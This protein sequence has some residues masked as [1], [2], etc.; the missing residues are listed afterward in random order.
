MSG[1]DFGRRSGRLNVQGYVDVRDLAALVSFLEMKGVR[2]PP[3]YS[4][5]QEAI[6][7]L[8][9]DS[10]KERGEAKVFDMEEAIAALDI[11]GFS[12]A[13]LGDKRGNGMQKG[14]VVDAGAYDFAPVS[15]EQ[16]ELQDLVKRALATHTGGKVGRLSQGLD[17]SLDRALPS[18]VEEVE[19]AGRT[20][21]M[22]K[23]PANL[24]IVEDLDNDGGEE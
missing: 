13:Q 15:S 19:E 2:I 4:D 5:L 21:R 14:R 18:V 3:R 16:R 23:L 20:F 9:L 8:V 6:F 24:R 12:L 1:K 17:R 10:V 11:R 22:E 7:R